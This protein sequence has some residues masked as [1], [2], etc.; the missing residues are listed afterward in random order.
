MDICPKERMEERQ[1]SK[2]PYSV[3]TAQQDTVKQ[4]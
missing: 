3:K 1:T 2:D 4:N